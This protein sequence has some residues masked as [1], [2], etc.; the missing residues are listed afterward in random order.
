MKALS[1]RQPWAHYVVHL[2]KH[3]E[4]RVWNTS[5]RGQFLIHAS[6]GMTKNEYAEAWR[7]VQN[8]GHACWASLPKY[9]DIVRGGIIG[10]ATLV[11]VV[12][13]NTSSLYPALHYPEGVDGRWHMREQYAFILRDIRPTAFVPWNGS[14]GFFEVGDDIAAQAIAGAP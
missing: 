12:P 1:L 3:I 5:F 9:A 11:G 13:P 8:Q 2:G 10:V 6:K 14:L 7:W 4:N